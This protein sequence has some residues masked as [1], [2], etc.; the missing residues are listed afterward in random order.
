MKVLVLVGLKSFI[1][2]GQYSVY[3]V[4]H[5]M[6]NTKKL[7][8][9]YNNLFNDGSENI[10][11]IKIPITNL[12]YLNKLIELVYDIFIIPFLI[13]F[14]RIDLVVGSQRKTAI[15]ANYYKKIF[16]VKT[17]IFIFETPEL[18][19]SHLPEWNKIYKTNKRFNNSWSKF[20]SSL[21]NAN[22]VISNSLTTF[23]YCFDWT[24]VESFISYPGCEIDLDLKAQKKENYL[25]YIGRLEKHKNI[26]LLVTAFNQIETNYTLIIC[27][28][29]KEKNKIEMLAKAS[30]NKI[31]LKGFVSEEEK[32]NL[33]KRASFLVYP[34]SFEGFGMPPMEAIFNGTPVLCSDIPI[35][36][37]VY[38]SSVDYFKNGDII[39][40][41]SKIIYMIN[42]H[43]NILKRKRK[44]YLS[45]KE[46]Y[47]W[48]NSA[49][50]L[51]SYIL[52]NIFIK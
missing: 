33:I 7:I 48:M 16:N 19:S 9:A 44:C 38:S 4:F 32:F 11:N 18:L 49:E 17:C 25:I 46:K 15:M 24:G 45:L 14:F 52:N 41:E 34:S 31:I 13:L 30:K 20:K 37:E 12:N 21:M 3:K 8:F 39:D 51:N 2:G 23:N 40:L 26:D 42:N 36:K 29:G 5:N 6:K 28:E 35:L 47:N 27:G 22:F 50:K 10:S 43:S 1:S